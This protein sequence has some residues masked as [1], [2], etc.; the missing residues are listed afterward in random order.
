VNDLG[1]SHS[2]VWR[3]RA[4][5]KRAPTVALARIIQLGELIFTTIAEIIQITTSTMHPMISMIT[6]FESAHQGQLGTGSLQ[7]T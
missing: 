6:H 7:L 4:H 3:S 1:D 5:S 2:V